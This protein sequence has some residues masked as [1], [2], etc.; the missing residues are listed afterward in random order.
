MSCYAN[1][2]R[3]ALAACRSAVSKPSVN[4]P[5]IGASR[6]VGCGPLALRLP[7]PGQAHRGPQLQRLGLLA[8][9]DVK[10]L[11]DA[12]CRRLG[13]GPCVRQQ[14]CAPEPMQLRFPQAYGALGPHGQRVG[15]GFQPFPVC[16]TWADASA[17]RARWLGPSLPGH[18]PRSAGG[19]ARLD[20]RSPLRPVSTRSQ[21]PAP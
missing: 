16:P 19:Q 17:S 15:Q 11:L 14:S 20:R 18:P 10:G 1:A 5:L 6:G 2:S 3:N 8:A 7:P 4:Q 12:G 9:G 21:R 13:R